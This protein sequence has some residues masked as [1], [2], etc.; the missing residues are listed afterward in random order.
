MMGLVITLTPSKGLATPGQSFEEASKH[1]AY[2]PLSQPV[3]PRVRQA[4]RVQTPIDAFVLSRLEENG[5]AFSPP[6]D[7]R[8]L[9]RRVYYDL[10][11]LPPAFEEIQ[12]FE[13]DR[14][15]NAFSKV[16]ERLL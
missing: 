15:R 16:V 5:L 6:A 13:R 8:S 7:Q 9:L 1:W 3:L 14:S 12:A 10:I 11:G 2:Q 4:K